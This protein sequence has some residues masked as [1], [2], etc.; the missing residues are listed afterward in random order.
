MLLR[1]DEVHSF[2]ANSC[3]NISFSVESQKKARD[4]RQIS[5]NAGEKGFELRCSSFRDPT[6]F[7]QHLGVEAKKIFH[8]DIL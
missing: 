6:A 1:D 8:I 2:S 7:G 4:Q 5:K 3:L